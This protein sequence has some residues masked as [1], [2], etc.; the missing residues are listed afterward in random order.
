MHFSALY[1]P[2]NIDKQKAQ[3]RDLPM[4]FLFIAM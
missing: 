1:D 4:G 3:W 2:S